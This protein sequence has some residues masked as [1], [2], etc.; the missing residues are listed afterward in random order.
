MAILRQFGL[1]GRDFVQGAAS[2]CTYAS[3]MRYKQ[4]WCAQS[5]ASTILLL[6]CF[7]GGCFYRDRGAH[8][9]NAMR[10]TPMQALPVCGQ[11][12]L[13][14]R[15]LSSGRLVALAPFPVQAPCFHTALFVKIVGILGSY[16]PLVKLVC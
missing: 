13:G 4:P 3:Q 15:M 12:A 6:P 9:R 8:L 10:K 16:T 1:V 14:V 7:E 5:D 11:L 2:F